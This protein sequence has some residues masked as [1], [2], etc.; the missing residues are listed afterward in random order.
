MGQTKERIKDIIFGI[1]FYFYWFVVKRI[2]TRSY[3]Q[4]AVLVATVGVLSWYSLSL[5]IL[6]DVSLGGIPK[7]ICD[8]L[9]F[10]PLIVYAI[11]YI[12]Y[13]IIK[14]RYRRIVYNIKKYRNHKNLMRYYTFVASGMLLTYISLAV[15]CHHNQQLYEESQKEMTQT[16]ND[17]SN[18]VNNPPTE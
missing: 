4:Y 1:I 17:T 3:A 14:D 18:H 6:S 5:A 15:G 11:L 13:F 12:K 10:F 16:Q 9:F 2:K 7:L 8:I